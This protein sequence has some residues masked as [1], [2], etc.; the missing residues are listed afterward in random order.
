[1]T[2]E[3]I[4]IG[5]D[6]FF[7]PSNEAEVVALIKHARAQSLQVRGRGSTHSVAWSIYTDPTDG[8]PPNRTLQQ[9]PPPGE[10]NLAFDKMRDVVWIDETNGIIEA[11]PGINLGWDPQDP[12]GVS[13]PEN[14]LLHQIFEKGWAVNTLGG[15]IHQTLAGFTATGS[16]GGSTRYAWD[17]AIA[18]RI[19]DGTGKAEWIDQGHPDFDA[20]GTSMGLL[21]IV[22]RIR[23]QLVPMYNIKGTEK[24]TPIDCETAPMDFLGDG[25]AY[26]NQ[27]SLADYLKAEPYT[28]VV[29][30]PQKG[31]ERIQTWQAERV[32]FTNDGLKPYQQFTPDFGGQTEMFLGSVVFV[33]FGNTNPFRIIGLIWQKAGVYLNNLAYVLVKSGAGGFSR[34]LT[35]LLG[36]AVGI[37][38]WVLGL[39]LA[40][41]SGLVRL[42]FSTLLPAFNP[43]TK[44]GE[45]TLFNDYYWRSLCMD[46]TV[47]DGLLGTEFTEIWVP[48]QHTQTVMNLYQDMFEDGGASATGYFSTEVYGGPPSKGWMH[49]GY[50]DGTDE[51]KDGTVRIDVYWF[52]DNKGIPNADEGFL[53]QYWEVL[54][55]NGIPFRLHWGKFVPRYDFADWAEHYRTNLPRFA[56]FLALRETRDPDGLFFTD[57]WRKRLLGET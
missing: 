43:I 36:C 21:G 50:T 49:P 12:F 33:L 45:E 13:T 25:S 31:V 26:P 40:F 48:I 53:D 16:A 3:T 28:R 34:F 8:S 38:V 7:H 32:P 11:G 42:A 9:S 46:N 4:A 56:D 27:P 19:V 39:V 47:S 54:R 22:T 15:I 23:M 51:Y 30:W 17:N 5:S 2:I 35:Y 44:P 18:F 52:R 29:W 41:L 37:I 10:I 20:V 14:S 1:M 6:G 57:Y 24:T 55:D